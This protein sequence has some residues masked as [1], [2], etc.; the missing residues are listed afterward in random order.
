MY[1]Y[2]KQILTTIFHFVYLD[3]IYL[4]TTLF[5]VTYIQLHHDFNL[6]MKY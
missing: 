3:F 1:I 4:N 2:T 6:K 5:C